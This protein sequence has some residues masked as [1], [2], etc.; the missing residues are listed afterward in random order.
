MI[1]IA[2]IGCGYWGPNYIRTF[3]ELPLAKVSLCCDIDG[4]RVKRIKEIYPFVKASTKYVDVVKNPEIDA[5]CISTPASTHYDLTKESLLHGK[6]VLVEK[7]L[8]LSVK[9]GDELVK[10]AEEQDRIL[11]VGHVYLYHPVVQKLKEYIQN[12]ELNDLY[13]LYSLRTGL[14]PIR[15]DANAMWDLA[16]HDISIYLHLLDQLPKNVSARGASYLQDG[17]EDVVVLS[18]EFSRRI[19]GYVHVSWLD[20]YKVRKLTI[21]SKSK[22]I[23]FDDTSSGEKMKV[24]SQGVVPLE[25]STYGEFLLQVRTGDIHV[26]K[27]DPIEPLRNQCSDFIG[28][29]E[30]NLSPISNGNDGVKVVRVL[31]AA[32][33]SLRNRGA[34]I[35]V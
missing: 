23:V 26:P 5:V 4:D 11:M 6:H 35:D 14:G 34:A 7:P 9:E 15:R 28:C 19:M 33:K 20:A 22:M 18:M 29:I 12:D 27:I 16:P 21:V 1:R 10:I 32:Q 8:A 31:E 25:P 3:N 13:Y 2:I 30:R 24:F 17:V